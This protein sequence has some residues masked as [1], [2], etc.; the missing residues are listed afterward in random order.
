VGLWTSLSHKRLP[1]LSVI[2]FV[3]LW[4]AVSATMNPILLPSPLSV[5]TSFINLVLSGDILSA[6]AISFSDLAVGFL[7]SAVAGLV[8]GLL[9]GRYGT[10]EAVLTPYVAFFIA[11]PSIA[12]VPLIIIWFGFG[13]AARVVV[14]VTGSVWPII[15]NTCAGVKSTDRQL[16]QLSH[17][18]R[19]STSQYLRWV[20]LPNALPYIVSGF[21]LGLGSAIVSMIVAQ[22]TMELVGLG[23]LIMTY[24]NAF[25]SDNMLA[26]IF[27]TSLFG[28]LLTGAIDLL[29]RRLFPWIRGQTG[30]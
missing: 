21:K 9:M 7:I 20:A 29:E 15:I 24:G 6:F 4:Q 13:D 14:I 23:G 28:V 5:V 16:R 2:V 8:I 26:A 12:L 27:S 1:L 17:A 25:R 18:F 11:T 19:L 3:V 22:M 30:L 10:L